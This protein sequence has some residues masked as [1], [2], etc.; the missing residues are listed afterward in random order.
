MKQGREGGHRKGLLFSQLLLWVPGASF[1]WGPLG[2]RVEPFRVIP[3]EDHGASGL[4]ATNLGGHCFG[5]AAGGIDFEHYWTA[6]GGLWSQRK[7][8]AKTCRF[9]QLEVGPAL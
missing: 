5:A 6:G 8:S 1:P 2:A 7:P 4:Y 9:L 3:P